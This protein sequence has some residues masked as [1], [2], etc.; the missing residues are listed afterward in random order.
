MKLGLLV[1][2][3]FMIYIAF[4]KETYGYLEGEQK[5]TDEDVVCYARHSSRDSNAPPSELGAVFWPVS[6]PLVFAL[7]NSRFVLETG[8]LLLLGVVLIRSNVRLQI[9]RKNHS[10][11]LREPTVEQEALK[12]VDRFLDETQKP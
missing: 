7:R 5:K 6:L 1:L 2:L 10:F 4:G 8:A 3:G 11:R 9:W 12:E